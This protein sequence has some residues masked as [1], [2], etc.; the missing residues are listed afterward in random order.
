MVCSWAASKVTTPTLA[1]TRRRVPSSVAVWSR[2]R[3]TTCGRAL[4]RGPVG[5]GQQDGEL[6][7]PEA[8]HDVGG[9][10]ALR[11]RLA[12]EMISWSPAPWP[13]VSL[14]SLKWS[15]SSSRSAPVGP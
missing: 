13:R 9:A 12:A 4:G 1:V 5:V 14:T 10:D 2:I 15:R 3:S 6:V 8:G 11:S 7:A